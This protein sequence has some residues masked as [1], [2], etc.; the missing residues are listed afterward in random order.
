[1]TTPDDV[2]VTDP[3]TGLAAKVG[4]APGD[5]EQATAIRAA[6]KAQSANERAIPPEPAD[7]ALTELAEPEPEAPVLPKV[8]DPVTLQNFTAEVIAVYPADELRPFA[9]VQLRYLATGNRETVA[10]NAVRL[11]PKV[12]E[13]A[14]IQRLAAVKDERGL[15]PEEE[16]EYYRLLGGRYDRDGSHNLRETKPRAGADPTG[17]P[18]HALY[19]EMEA[20]APSAGPT[21]PGEIR[22]QLASARDLDRSQTG[23]GDAHMLAGAEFPAPGPPR[24]SIQG[25]R[26]GPEASRRRA[27]RTTGAAQQGHPR[28]LP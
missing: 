6:L 14:R 9:K 22:Q 3:I 21:I 25:R 13:W 28:S 8:G 5:K 7:Q 23:A 1:M 4:Q 17:E 16:T 11:A 19:A 15:T 20:A 18:E 27:A 26:G 10:A 24:S 2:T 12:D